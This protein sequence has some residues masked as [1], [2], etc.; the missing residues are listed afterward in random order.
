M[1]PMIKFKTKGD[2]SRIAMKEAVRAIQNNFE[3]VI[4]CPH[5]KESIEVRT[6]MNTCPSCNKTIELKF[7]P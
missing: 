1:K 7:K 2:L 3:T 5:C 6:G 4:S